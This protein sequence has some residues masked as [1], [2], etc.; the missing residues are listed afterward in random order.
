MIKTEKPPA[1]SIP[2]TLF[3][4]WVVAGLVSLYP[5]AVHLRAGFP[6]FT[7]IWL[8]VPLAAVLRS[9]NPALVGFRMAPARLFW[10][11]AAINL[12]L[13]LLAMVLFEPWSHAYGTL[14]REAI[15]GDATFAW[16]ARYP[17]PTRWLL[18]FIFSGLVT[19]FAE[20]L[21]FRGWLLQLIL[22]R[23]GRWFAIV[24]QA[25]L[26]TLLQALPAFFLSPVQALVWVVVYSFLGVGL[27]NGWAA[28]R[29]NS[30]WPG[31]I[32]ATFMNL[33]VTMLM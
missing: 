20:E 8:V 27:I 16:L 22:R 19:M 30:I 15:K 32:A 6:F 10:G 31:L 4:L 29:T 9:H 25:L 11:T 1:S 7:L 24:L 33:I 14:V 12:G 5:V 18:M 17:S 21:F 28:S 3:L 23:R 2:N 13:L 26:F